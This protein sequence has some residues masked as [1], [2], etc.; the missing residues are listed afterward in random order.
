MIRKANP[1]DSKIITRIHINSWKTTYNK[2]FPKEVFEN[3]EKSFEQRKNQI[4]DAI[5]NDNEYHYIVYEENNIIKGFA[6]YGNGRGENYK[7]I[8]EVYSIYLE[9]K[10][11]R[12]GIGSKLIK[13]C[14]NNLKKEG[15]KNIIIRC[16]KGNPSEN[17]YKSLGGKVI[18]IENGIIGETQIEEN[19]YMFEI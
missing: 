4:R 7:N 15:Y 1:N 18:N 17:F 9:Q 13:E 10:N 11:Q 19:I 12:K 14:F 8:G 16:L 3:Q 6:C 5:E 2:F